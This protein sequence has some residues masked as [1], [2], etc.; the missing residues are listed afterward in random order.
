M[1]QYVEQGG[2]ISDHDD[3]PDFIRQ[4]IVGAEEQRQNKPKSSHHRGSFYPPINITN[5]LPTPPTSVTHQMTADHELTLAPAARLDSTLRLTVHGYLD[6]AVLDYTDWKV[7]QT[8]SDIWKDGFRCA[9]D[10]ALQLGLYLDLP[11]KKGKKVFD[12]YDIPEG[13]VEQYARDIPI[14]IE[15]HHRADEV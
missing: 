13:L 11:Y 1:V 6:Q 8:I 2:T 9:G 10:I 15:N 3:V 4:E 14:W 7:S 5:V 12:G